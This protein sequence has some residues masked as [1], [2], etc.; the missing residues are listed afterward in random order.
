MFAS[1]FDKKDENLLDISSY[2]VLCENV[3][4]VACCS[5]G[6]N[7]FFFIC[8]YDE[9]CLVVQESPAFLAFEGHKG[10]KIFFAK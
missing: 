8:S 3:L 5:L 9:A 10:Q 6:W 1:L 2:Y 4:S 7:E